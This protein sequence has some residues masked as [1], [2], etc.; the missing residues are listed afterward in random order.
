MAQAPPSILTH[1][2]RVWR[3]DDLSLVG[4]IFQVESALPRA[5]AVSR[6][7]HVIHLA[8]DL[9][10]GRESERVARQVSEREEVLGARAGLVLEET[11]AWTNIMKDIVGCL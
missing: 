9:E 2:V 5:A 1:H 7:P 4:P 8:L 3:H 11:F 6:P 10:V